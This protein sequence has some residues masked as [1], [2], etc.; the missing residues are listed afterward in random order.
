MVRELVAPPSGEFSDAEPLLGMDSKP[1]STYT[2]T[3]LVALAFGITDH[4][5]LVNFITSSEDQVQQ[6]S[7]RGV[8]LPPNVKKLGAKDGRRVVELARTS[9]GAGN[10]VVRWFRSSSRHSAMLTKP[11][12]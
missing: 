3:K 10:H 5:H 8:Q 4:I 6:H 11:Y 7:S 9:Q 2:A 12:D 1:V